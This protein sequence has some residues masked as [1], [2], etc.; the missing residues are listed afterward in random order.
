MP[1]GADIARDSARIVLLD[2]DLGCLHKAR[3]IARN[4]YSSVDACFYSTVGIN[5][6]ILFLASLGRLS[7]ITSAMLHNLSTIGILGYTALKN[8]SGAYNG[9]QKLNQLLRDIGGVKDLV[10]IDTDKGGP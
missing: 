8:N 10:Q 3:S 2:D 6:V 4:Y 5:S 9:P 7:P 1:D